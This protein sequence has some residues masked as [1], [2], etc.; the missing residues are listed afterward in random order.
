M[1][2]FYNELGNWTG[3]YTEV[4]ASSLI[5]D[6]NW[7]LLESE[8]PNLLAGII[9]GDDDEFGVFSIWEYMF[10]DYDLSKLEI[11]E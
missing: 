7:F 3:W 11:K 9:L 8:N 2:P 1:I 10:L 4:S 5:L 6:P